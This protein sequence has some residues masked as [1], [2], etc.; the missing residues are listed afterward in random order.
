[1][2]PCLSEKRKMMKLSVQMV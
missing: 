2:T 1:M